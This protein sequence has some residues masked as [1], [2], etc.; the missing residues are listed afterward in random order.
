MRTAGNTDRFL[1]G[2][3]D[4]TIHPRRG[5]QAAALNADRTMALEADGLSFAGFRGHLQ[6][7][8]REGK[9]I[10]G[11]AEKHTRLGCRIQHTAVN[12][13]GR[14]VAAQ[15]NSHIAHINGHIERTIKCQLAVFPNVESVAG[16][17]R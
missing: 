5:F 11:F 1:A 15:V 6:C 9:A 2:V 10:A 16:G 13:C 17:T 8:V 4:G 7:A 14:T 12:L 3:L